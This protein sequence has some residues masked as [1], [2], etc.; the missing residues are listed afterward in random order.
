MCRNLQGS[1]QGTTTQNF[2]QIM[3]TGQTV[4]HEGFH[5]DFLEFLFFSQKLENVQIDSAE[6]NAVWVLET[7]LWERGAEGAFDHLQNQSSCCSQSV[8]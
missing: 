6:F 7:K 5:I 2:Y 3:L 4:L 8:T 1:R